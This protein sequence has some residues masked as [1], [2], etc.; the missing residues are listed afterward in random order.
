ME[1]IRGTGNPADLLT[2]RLDGNRLT[3]LCDLLS[4]K[5]LPS[6]A[7]QLTRDAE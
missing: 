1:K 4:T 6:S 7:L 5:R 2:K 3:T